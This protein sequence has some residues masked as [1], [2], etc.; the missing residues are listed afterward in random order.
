M[1][2]PGTRSMPR[3]V[4]WSPDGTRIALGLAGDAGLEVR[5]WDAR[6]E[7]LRGL[8]SGNRARSARSAGRPTAAG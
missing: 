3:T 5:S 7:R 4:A 2:R 1:R 6:A 8:S